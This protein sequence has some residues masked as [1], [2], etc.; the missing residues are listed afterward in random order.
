MSFAADEGVMRSSGASTGFLPREAGAEAMA[1]EPAAAAAVGKVNPEATAGRAPNA[2]GVL[3]R[4]SNVGC[5][6]VYAP[7]ALVGHAGVVPAKEGN[8]GAPAAPG[9]ERAGAG[10]W[11]SEEVVPA[12]LGAGSEEKIEV[13]GAVAAGAPRPGKLNRGAAAGAAVGIAE[14]APRPPERPEPNAGM[15]DAAVGKEVG[16]RELCAAAGA[17]PKSPPVA[18]AGAA[19]GGVAPNMLVPV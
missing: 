15:L 14:N 16:K 11:N 3:R 18:N 9:K 5:A 12:K 13:E 19:V 1:Y 6:A 4:T 8:A 2:P 10:V 7:A 17:A